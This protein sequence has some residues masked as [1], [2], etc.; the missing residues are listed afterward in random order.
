MNRVITFCY[1]K[2]ID[3]GSVR[4][5]EKMV[6]DDTY[7]EF[8]MQFQFFNQ[9]RKFNSF[10]GLLH[11]SPLEAEKMH[12]LVSAAASGYVKQLSG[13]IPDIF[14]ALGRQF[15]VFSNFSFE[16]INSDMNE[17]DKHQVAVS[18]YSEPLTWHD[19]IGDQMLLS[20]IKQEGNEILTHLVR[21]QPFLSIHSLNYV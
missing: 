6:F 15:L 19:T 2:I 11:E 4:P 3:A 17:R 8:R 12:F 1:R 7:Q 13:R 9:Q 10:A 18:F 5:W 14:N 21:L 20:D 16:V